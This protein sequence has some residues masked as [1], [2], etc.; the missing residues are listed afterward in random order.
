MDKTRVMENE[1]LLTHK[2]LISIKKEDRLDKHGVPPTKRLFRVPTLDPSPEFIGPWGTFG[3]P[4]Q[5]RLEGTLLLG[6]E[7]KG[8]EVVK[9]LAIMVDDVVKIDLKVID[10]KEAK[11]T[12]FSTVVSGGVRGDDVEDYGLSQYSGNGRVEGRGLVRIGVEMHNDFIDRR[13]VMLIV[14]DV[15]DRRALMRTNSEIGLVTNSDMR[16][17]QPYQHLSV[18]VVDNN[19]YRV[20]MLKGIFVE[21]KKKSETAVR[22]LCQE[23]ITIDLKDHAAVDQY[24]KVMKTVRQNHD[25]AWRD[26]ASEEDSEDV[27]DEGV[28]EKMMKVNPPR[29]SPDGSDW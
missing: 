21:V 25:G 22:V 3:D 15:I 9:E 5:P 23:K 18:L 12:A 4:G 20:E 8:N 7:D 10:D 19:H 29:V 2:T 6:N 26:D 11:L 1:S 16:P 24:D 28:V 27:V 14:T 13:V 17:Y